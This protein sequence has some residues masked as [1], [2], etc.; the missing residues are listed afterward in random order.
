MFWYE[1]DIRLL[2]HKLDNIDY[3]PG[4]A[5]YGSSS[6]RLWDGLEQSFPNKNLVNLGFGGS[7]LAACAWFFERVFQEYVPTSIVV[8][9]GDN[10]LGDNRHPEEVFIFYRE[11]LRKVRESFGNIPFAYVSVKPSPARWYLIESIRF[12]NHIVRKDLEKQGEKHYFIDIFQ[13]MLGTDGKPINAYF[14]PDGLHLSQ[15]GYRIWRDE[16]LKYTSELF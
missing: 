4:V 3:K 15:E 11:L 9:A 5:F 14:E 2:E 7:T 6:F 10:D 16:I 12:F 13:R 1:N 8:Y